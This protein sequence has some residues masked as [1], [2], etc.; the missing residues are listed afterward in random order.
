VS[1]EKERDGHSAKWPSLVLLGSVPVGW[2]E[3]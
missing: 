1:L 3:R 2:T